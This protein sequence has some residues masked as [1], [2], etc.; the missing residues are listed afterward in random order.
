V[1]AAV[2]SLPQDHL[3]RNASYG[4]GST[5]DDADIATINRTMEACSWVEPWGRDDVVLVGNTAVAHGR[6]LFHG[7]RE[8]RVAMAGAGS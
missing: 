3:P 4:D 7:T 5:I 6:H 1:A 2:R 8:V